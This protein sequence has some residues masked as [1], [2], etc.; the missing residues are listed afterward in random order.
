MGL[1]ENENDTSGRYMVE[2]NILYSGG[3]REASKAFQELCRQVLGDD[4]MVNRKPVEISAG[5][6]NFRAGFDADLSRF[7]ETLAKLLASEPEPRCRDLPRHRH[8]FANLAGTVWSVVLGLVCVPLFIRFLG[9][10]AFGLIGLSLAMQSNS[11][12]CS[13][14]ST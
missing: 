9:A 13:S 3:L 10:E 2:L 14:W 5:H 1:P 12:R 4:F 7:R 6:A 8:T 11:A